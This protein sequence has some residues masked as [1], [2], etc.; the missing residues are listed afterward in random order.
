MLEAAKHSSFK[1]GAGLSQATALRSI[2]LLGCM[3][4]PSSPD[5]DAVTLNGNRLSFFGLSA[6]MTMDS[7]FDQQVGNHDATWCSLCSSVD[8]L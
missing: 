1:L 8:H 7:T 5:I 3:A 2:S 4:L 6:V